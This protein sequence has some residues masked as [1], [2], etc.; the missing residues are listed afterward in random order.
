M[1]RTLLTNEKCS[2]SLLKRIIDGV[3]RPL[4]VRVLIKMINV[5]G[6]TISDESVRI[7]VV[8]PLT[9]GNRPSY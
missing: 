9:N 8:F 6:G 5:R 3:L 2:R 7:P 1:E 4:P